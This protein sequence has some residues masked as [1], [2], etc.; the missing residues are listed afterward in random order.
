MLII[1][2][3]N[4]NLI[5]L[6]KVCPMINFLRR[7]F[8]RRW[9]GHY[10]YQCPTHQDSLVYSKEYFGDSP[11]CQ[12]P[13]EW[14]CTYDTEHRVKATIVAEPTSKGISSTAFMLFTCSVCGYAVLNKE[15]CGKRMS[16]ISYPIF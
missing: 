8:D 2:K 4:P 6:I 12:C 16:L 3:P 14:A 9:W 1:R 13:T 5:V 10:I 15:V 7:I 11:M